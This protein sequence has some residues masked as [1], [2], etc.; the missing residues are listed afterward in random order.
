MK[1]NEIMMGDYFDIVS[2]RGN[3]KLHFTNGR[4]TAIEND[5]FVRVNGIRF[6]VN[7]L[8]GTKL[9]KEILAKNGFEHLPIRGV[10]EYSLPDKENN[11]I[12]KLICNQARILNLKYVHELQH[13]LRLCGLNE[14]ADNFKLK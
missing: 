3:E 11:I 10:Y 7:S 1:V 4:I 5:R 8:E 2:V 14:M 6:H 13:A 12:V 9:T